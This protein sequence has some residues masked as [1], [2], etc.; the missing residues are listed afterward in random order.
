MIVKSQ[1]DVCWHGLSVSLS[2]VN[3]ERTENPSLR[4]QDL[5]ITSRLACPATTASASTP[6][7]KHKINEIPSYFTLKPLFPS[8][9]FHRFPSSQPS[10]FPSS[11]RL[12]KCKPTPS[13]MCLWP[14]PF[15]LQTTLAIDRRALYGDQ[16]GGLPRRPF[17]AFSR[18]P[19]LSH[20]QTGH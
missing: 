6:A 14:Y 5:R 18:S 19:S 17:S 15:P 20:T 12:K 2:S 11:Q 3:G 4:P 1:Y 7:S 9:P 13:F 10:S 8:I 16:V